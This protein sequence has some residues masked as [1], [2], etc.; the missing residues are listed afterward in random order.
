[1]KSIFVGSCGSIAG[2]N[3]RTKN[4]AYEKREFVSNVSHELRTPL[5]YLQGYTEALLDG[6]AKDS[7]EKQKY[8]N[9]IHE[10]T[11]RARRLV[12][13]LLDLSRIETGQIAIDKK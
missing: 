12:N 1:M 9:I 11:L 4:R 3:H 10:E 13:E 5:S 8:L 7:D 6:M 2:R